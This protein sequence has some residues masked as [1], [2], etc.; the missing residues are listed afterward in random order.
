M[1]ALD[2]MRARM[3]KKLAA[4]GVGDGRVLRAMGAVERHRFVDGALVSQAYE[5]TSL[6]IGLGQTIS[7]PNVVGRMV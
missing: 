2:A 3:V 7:K 6:P 1:M 5:D 4:L